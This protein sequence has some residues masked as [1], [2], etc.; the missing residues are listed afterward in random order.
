MKKKKAKPPS[1]VRYEES[2]PVTS[3]R[4]SKETYDDLH[5]MKGLTGC[6]LADI[7]KA[8]IDKQAIDVEVAYM[9]GREDAEDVLAVTYRCSVCGKVIVVDSDEEK[10]A[11]ARYM[12]E[13]GWGHSDCVR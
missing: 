8:A 5:K 9:K 2:H 12:S 4:V 13:H 11:I 10:K 1:R 6:S 3:F 7:V